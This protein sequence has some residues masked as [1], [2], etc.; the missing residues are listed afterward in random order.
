ML[1]SYTFVY[2]RVFLHANPILCE[3]VGNREKSSERSLVVKW[4]TQDQKRSRSRIQKKKKKKI[5]GNLENSKWT[6]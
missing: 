6:I 5:I 2:D 4:E 3:K 1:S